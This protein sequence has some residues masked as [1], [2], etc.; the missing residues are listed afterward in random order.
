MQ[1][2]IIKKLAV[3]LNIK[4]Y[5]LNNKLLLK[6]SSVGLQMTKEKYLKI[7]LIFT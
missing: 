6:S 7:L 2:H 1:I 4:Q 3:A 5:N